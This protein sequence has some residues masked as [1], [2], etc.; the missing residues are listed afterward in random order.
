L[1][2]GLL[3]AGFA[4]GIPALDNPT[5]VGWRR[6]AAVRLL[7]FSE[8]AFGDLNQLV[9]TGHGQMVR[10]LTTTSPALHPEVPLVIDIWRGRHRRDR[11]RRN[12]IFFR[13]PDGLRLG[14]GLALGLDRQRVFGGQ[15]L[16]RRIRDHR[17]LRLFLRGRIVR[18]DPWLGSHRQ[19]L[20]RRLTRSSGRSDRRWRPSEISH[21]QELPARDRRE[22]AHHDARV[23]GR[24][25]APSWRT[26][27]FAASRPTP[28]R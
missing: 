11:L 22:S 12:R 19:L 6:I 25:Q 7:S 1:T 8:L 17:W 27:R 13:R 3:A 15:W 18:N 16:V 28:L 2:R 9:V 10:T 4:N 20:R 21:P 26:F 24:P 5:L 14:L 23:C